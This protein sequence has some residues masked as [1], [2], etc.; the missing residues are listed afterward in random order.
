MGIANANAE[1]KSNLTFVWAMAEMAEFVIVMSRSTRTAQYAKSQF[2]SS[3]EKYHFPSEA[4][5]CSFAA[6]GVGDLGLSIS[7]LRERAIFFGRFSST[8]SFMLSLGSF[9]LVSATFFRGRPRFSGIRLIEVGLFSPRVSRPITCPSLS[10][11]S[12]KAPASMQS[13]TNAGVMA[14]L[15]F[16]RRLANRSLN[17]PDLE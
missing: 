15:P 14:G 13:S 9:S 16:V 11:T 3:A 1:K 5:I 2:L 4:L 12:N 7:S 10:S 17:A 6:G 8:L